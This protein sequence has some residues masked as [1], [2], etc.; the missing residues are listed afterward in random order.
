MAHRRLTARA[1]AASLALAGLPLAGTALVDAQAVSACSAPYLPL[2]GRS[3]YV[4]SGGPGVDQKQL[5]PAQPTVEP[6]ID[7][8]QPGYADATGKDEPD[9]DGDGVTDTVTFDPFTIRRGDGVIT[10]TDPDRGLLSADRYYAAD[11][12]ADGRDELFLRSGSGPTFD[13]DRYYVLPGTTAPGTYRADAVAIRLPTP[14]EVHLAIDRPPVTLGFTPVGN[15]DGEPGEDLLVALDPSRAGIV[16]GVDLLAPGPGGTVAAYDPVETIDPAAGS[17]L[18]AL[19]VGSGAPALAFYRSEGDHATITLWNQGR[20]ANYRTAG[21]G[22]AAA[23]ANYANGHAA[24]VNTDD[25]RTLLVVTTGGR[26]L[27]TSY[28]WGLDDPCRALPLAGDGTPTPATGSPAPPTD[29]RGAGAATPATP[30]DDRATYT[31]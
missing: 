16:S 30:V 28:Y 15:Q 7:G 18:S 10:I 6:S 8:F 27:N 13:P 9:T 3:A 23:D 31:G 26:G 22:A 2:Y 12:D 20:L 17:F 4:N 11:L 25:G 29:G 5:Y 19:V 14:P 24:W 1:L 21:P